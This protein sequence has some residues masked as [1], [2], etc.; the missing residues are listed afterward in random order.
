M[1]AICSTGVSTG[2]SRGP[3]ASEDGSSA[4]IHLPGRDFLHGRYGTRGLGVPEG[5]RR[6]RPARFDRTHTRAC[7]R[8]ALCPSN[9]DPN[10]QAFG[11]VS[12]LGEFRAQQLQD[13]ALSAKL[14][15]RV[16]KPSD[17]PSKSPRSLAVRVRRLR[18]SPVLA[19]SR[20][21]P[22]Y[23]KSPARTGSPASEA[24][25]PHLTAFLVIQSLFPPPGGTE[26]RMPTRNPPLFCGLAVPCL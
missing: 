2:T 24:G 22:L 6:Q 14:P 21:P 12:I 8:Q 9:E 4:K 5:S 20:M 15:Q 25:S 3:R 18:R 19:N 23:A 26:V 17:R 11:R 7:A 1:D 10:Q 16:V 13:I